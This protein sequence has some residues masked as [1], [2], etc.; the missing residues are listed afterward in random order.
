MKVILMGPPGAGKG[1]LAQMMALKGYKHLSTGDMLRDEIK[2]GS[3]LGKKIDDLISNGKY[4]DDELAISL[5]KNK[6][7]GSVVLDGF[8][9]TVKQAEMLSE[10]F[11][12]KVVLLKVKEETVL[13]RLAERTVCSSCG[14][15]G[16]GDVCGRCSSK[17]EKR[18]DDEAEI[19]KKRLKT[20][21]ETMVPVIAFYKS[22]GIVLEIDVD[23]LT[24]EQ[25]LSAVE[26]YVCNY[27]VY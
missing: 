2:S 10:I 21:N 8:P 1:T 25:V 26:A 6:L 7:N 18:K 13:N 19:I 23:N 14:Y 22:Q 3:E 12:G 15:T 16:K 11:S 27:Y 4:V 17:M 24:E 20:Y 9:R 5:V